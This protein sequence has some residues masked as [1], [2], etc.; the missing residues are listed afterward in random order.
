ML[1]RLHIDTQEAAPTS[2]HLVA[3]Q[4]L[5]DKECSS[6]VLPVTL[7]ELV[8]A[9]VSTVLAGR[10]RAEEESKDAKKRKLPNYA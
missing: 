7:F 1:I 8:V 5:Y 3:T 2:L 6:T 4:A 10:L 9:S